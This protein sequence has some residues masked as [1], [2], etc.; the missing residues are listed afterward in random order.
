MTRRISIL[1]AT[2]A[3]IG[4][5]F[6]SAA[7]AQDS[8][9]SMERIFLKPY[10]QGSQPESP[11]ISADGK[12]IFYRWDSTAMGKYRQ[13]M[14]NA[15]GSGAHKLAD[16]L[17]GEIEFSPDGKTVACTRK[18]NIDLTDPTFGSFTQLTRSDDGDGNLHWSHDG[19]TLVFEEHDMIIAMH[20]DKPG[21]SQVVKV[22]NEKSNLS[23]IDVFPDGKHVLFNETNSDSEKEYLIPKYTG[24][25]V[26]TST[27]GGGIPSM[28]IGV[29][30]IDSP[31]VVWLKIPNDA[32]Y[33]WG[34]MQISPDGKS[35]IVER[36][37]SDNKHREMF[38]CDADSGKATLV[39]EERNRAW[40]EGGLEETAWMPDGKHIVTLSEREGW[41][42]LYTMDPQGN[43]QEW[44]NDGNWEIHWFDID[45][46]GKTIYFQ[47]N[48]EE[49]QQYQIYALDL[50]SKNIRKL[51]TRVGT[52]ENCSMAKDG[53]FIVGR[54]SDYGKPWEL[55]RVNTNSTGAVTDEKALTNSTSKEFQ[56]YHWPVPEIVNF[57]ASDGT[58][59]AATIFKPVHFDASK[60]YPVAVFVHGAGYL[61]N[62]QRAWSYYEHEYMFGYR[63]MQE[64]YVV[65]EVEYRGS[66]GYGQKFR[67][68]VY[69]H[70]GGKDLQDELDGIDYLNSLGYIDTS[71]VGI[72]GGSY[73]GFMTLMGL[74][75]SNKYAC[76]AALRAVSS[77][78]NYYDHNSWYTESRLGK[79]KDNPEAY[80]ISSPITYADSLKKPLLILHG[81][82]DNNVFFQDAVQLIDKLQKGKKKFE[83]MMYPEES[84][85]FRQPESW[86]DEYSRIEEFFNRYLKK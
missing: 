74:F 58:S 84:H 41:N 78:E 75:L 33:F 44:L 1:A 46:S 18:G 86:Y 23:L 47:A 45:P 80:K 20:P 11:R 63:L 39:Y 34:S 73:G 83:V 67:T 19:K 61:Q 54:Y 13:W 69:M 21:Y 36:N 24:K 76:G 79:P 43:H 59:V 48:K 28:K 57:K 60:K 12:Y 3:A 31:S 30:A 53:S 85:G 56:S 27:I 15:D 70:L 14:M 77:W 82:V 81:M 68:D 6:V 42:R 25:E 17:A 8:L 37:S 51:T 9:L 2:L 49:R 40:V 64:G 16:T 35:I 66:A 50:E 29:A 52:Y 26:T 4:G 62:V 5:L 65:Y 10:I 72:Y 7:S 22:S 38:V 32:R 55:F 71:R